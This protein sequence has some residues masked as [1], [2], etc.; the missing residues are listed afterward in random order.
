MDEKIFQA[1]VDKELLKLLSVDPDGEETKDVLFQN[2][3]RLNEEEKKA[4]EL[5]ENPHL[6]SAFCKTML[7]FSGDIWDLS[8]EISKVIVT[9]CITGVIA[10]VPALPVV[11]AIIIIQLFFKI[12][13]EIYCK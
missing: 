4:K 1:E 10:P 7:R 11:T 3:G 5:L 9:A 12:E 2:D 13:L 8:K 6:K